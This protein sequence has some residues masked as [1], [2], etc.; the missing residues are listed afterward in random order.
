MFQLL[1]AAEARYLTRAVWRVLGVVVLLA[2]LWW[3]PLSPAAL[4]RPA[5]LL[6]NNQAQEAL[7]SYLELA[8]GWGTDSMRSEA[9]WRAGQ[10]ASVELQDVEQ[11]VSLFRELIHMWPESERVNQARIELATLYRLHLEDPVSAAE[12]WR[13]AVLDQADHPYAGQWLLAAGE[14]FYEAGYLSESDESWRTATDYPEVA[15]DAWLAL[16]RGHLLDDPEKA[17]GHYDHA[18]SSGAQGEAARLAR[19]GMATALELMDR[20]E[21]ALA[22]LDQALSLKDRLDDVAAT[23]ACHASVRAGRRLTVEEMNALLRDM[24]RTPN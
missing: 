15:V 14:A 13:T 23:M 11:A 20:A 7:D 24:E 3:S 22:E 1:P 10:V 2:G 12:N 16:G 17:Y 21:E 9:L 6:G 18:L 4:E 5:R 8:Y 19:L